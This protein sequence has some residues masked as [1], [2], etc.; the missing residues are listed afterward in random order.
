M[1]KDEKSKVPDLL[2]QRYD[3]LVA[4]EEARFILDN[5]SRQCEGVEA[6]REFLRKRVE[7]LEKDLQSSEKEAAALID[8]ISKNSLAWTAAR[9]HFLLGQK[10]ESAARTMGITKDAAR[11]AVYRSFWKAYAIIDNTE[12]NNVCSG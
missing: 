7:D 5:L 12:E 8:Q 3:Q 6:E 1:S 9:L 11:M 2:T 10:W 4:L